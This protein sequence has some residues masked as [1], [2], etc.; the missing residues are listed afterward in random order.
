MATKAAEDPLAYLQSLDHLGIRLDLAP[1]ERLMK[2]LGGPQTRFPAV[3]IAGTNGKGSI[4]ATVASILQRSGRNVGLYTSPHL[5]DVRER[6]RCNGEMISPA[7][8]AEGLRTVRRRVSED[9]TYFECI[10]AVAFL[11]FARRP[12]D[13]AVLEVGMGGRL[14]A[15]NVCRP[16]ATAISNISREHERY[17]GKTL[18]DIAAEKGG[19]IR[20]GG[21]CV[22]GARQ[23]A[24]LAVLEKICRERKAALYRLGREIRIRR[25]RNGRFSYR[26]PA[27]RFPSL[28]CA[29]AGRHQVDNAA[30]ALGLIDVLADRGMPVS[31]EAVIA[32]LE[33]THWPGRMEV[34]RERPTLVVDGAHNP[35]GIAALRRALRERYP[36]R[37][38]HLVF[39][40]LEDKDYRSMLRLILP[41]VNRVTLTRPS[42]DRAMAP[43][44]LVSLVERWGRQVEVREDP[45]DAVA[46]ALSEAET[47][48]VVCVAGSLYQI[49]DIRQRLFCRTGGG[50]MVR[51]RCS[52]QG[53][54]GQKGRDR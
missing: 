24:V 47:D 2:R 10:T 17:L 21:L 51:E 18:A 39:G 50:V 42:S 53:K 20:P 1:M 13:V 35:A 31:D 45:R 27:R 32:G 40:V 25:Q 30:I 9:I 14:D 34:L 16:L 26:G 22:T 41:A 43:Q 15:T 33:E 19:V 8:L 48:D 52:R 46:Q 5:V 4:A 29:L 49:G 36:G 38:R 7:D 44:D 54:K 6:I 23:K 11:H 28:T 3:L 12:V 37:R